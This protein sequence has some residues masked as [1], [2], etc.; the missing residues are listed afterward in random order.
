M[1]NASSGR[2]PYVTEWEAG[3]GV[4]QPKSKLSVRIPLSQ[5]QGT[6]DDGLSKGR[7]VQSRLS[8]GR[9][10][11]VLWEIWLQQAPARSLLELQLP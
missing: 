7:I 5:A 9:P 6:V 11:I 8:V 10:G 2:Y 1:N 3:V 4:A